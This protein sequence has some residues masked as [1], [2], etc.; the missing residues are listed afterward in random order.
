MELFKALNQSIKEYNNEVA[1]LREF[2]A[3]IAAIRAKNLFNL[4]EAFPGSGILTRKGREETAARK[5]EEKIR[6]RE[7]EDEMARQARAAQ[8]AGT[9]G[10]EKGVD[11]TG[12]LA[13]L[14]KLYGKPVFDNGV[15]PKRPTPMSPED[16]K[17]WIEGLAKDPKN[18]ELPAPVGPEVGNIIRKNGVLYQVTS[19]ANL[20]SIAQDKEGRKIKVD[21]AT[22]G[23]PEHKGGMTLYNVS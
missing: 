1:E 9:D 5:N 16:Y 6:Q 10:W 12:R 17:I 22:L 15:P 20:T 7:A 3:E 14:N 8:R 18:T 11:N 13:E 19:S 21:W 4:G 2:K 23:K